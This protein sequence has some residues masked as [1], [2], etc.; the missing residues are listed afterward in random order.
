MR[1]VLDCWGFNGEGDVLRHV[2]G[3]LSD[4]LDALASPDKEQRK[5]ADLTVI[6]QG[7]LVATDG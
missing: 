6:V 2:D 1:E 7:M 4:T 3:L 5:Q